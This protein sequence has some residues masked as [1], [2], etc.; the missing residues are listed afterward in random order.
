ME[1]KVK[2]CRPITA[3]ISVPGDKSI[4]HRAIMM[5]ALANGPCTIDGFLPSEDCLA[6]VSAFR[7]LGVKIM[8]EEEGPFGPTK[9]KVQGRKGRLKSPADTKID[10]GNSGTT[11][12][13]ISGILAGQPAGFKAELTGDESLMRRPMR[14]IIEPLTIMGGRLTAKGEGDTAPVVIRG[15]ELHSIDYQLPVASAQVKS[16]ILLAAL[17]TKG[18]STVTEPLRTRDHTERM[19]NYFRVKTLRDEER[20]SIWG[21]QTL[22]SRDFSVPGDVSSAAFWVIAA[23][24]MPGAHL[25]IRNVGLNETRTGILKTLI[26]MGA[27]ITEVIEHTDCGEPVGSIEIHGGRLKGTVIEGED[28]PN[29]IDELPV[30]AVAGALAEGRTKIRDAKELRV[31]ESDRIASVAN[32]LRLMGV[33][34][35]EFF[36][37]MEIHGGAKLKGARLN[38]FGDH[39][40]GMAFAIAGLYADGETIIEDTDCINTSYP[41]FQDQ[42]GKFMKARREDYTPVISSL[43][44]AIDFEPDQRYGRSTD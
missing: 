17:F 21:G 37:G 29:V 20:I 4:S 39:R 11:M 7:Q 31:K 6:T 14:R 25:S 26:R 38:S 41:G 9:L 43:N 13:L 36:D 24:A 8:V 5:A 22:E 32:N 15:A 23:S 27:Q 2:R 34:V 33:E 42:L 40:V 28:I 44:P 1:F 30:I 16:A 3:E 35:Q 18:K 12:R 19:L 10:C